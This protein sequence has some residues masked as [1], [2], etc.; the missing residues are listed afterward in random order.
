M[1]KINVSFNCHKFL[2]QVTPDSLVGRQISTLHPLSGGLWPVQEEKKGKEDKSGG[3]ET[4]YDVC[5]KRTG[6]DRVA[7]DM[8][9]DIH[10]SLP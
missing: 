7:T 4:S 6:S 9:E 8:M 1:K 3:S 2:L 10:V 5:S